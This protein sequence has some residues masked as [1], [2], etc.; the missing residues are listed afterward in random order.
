MGPNV[1]YPKE[2]GIYK[3]T[4]SDNGKIYIGK[5]VNL[6]NRIN[7]HKNLSKTLIGKCYFD[8]LM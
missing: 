6:Y 1:E 2:A 3:L 4:C 5:A 8:W 7:A